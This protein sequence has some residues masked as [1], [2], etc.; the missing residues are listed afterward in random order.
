MNFC[1]GKGWGVIFAVLVS[2]LAGCVKEPQHAH[3]SPVII[4]GDMELAPRPISTGDLL[5]LRDIGGYYGALSVSPDGNH[6]AFQVQQAMTKDNAYRTAWFVV[7]VKSGKYVYAG[8]GGEPILYGEA[9]GF[10]NGARMAPEAK[11][12]PNGKW[13]AYQL[14]RDGEIQLW[15]SSA[16]G[17][18]QE[19]LSSNAGNV[20]VL[21]WSDSGEH[22]YFKAGASRAAQAAALHTE[23]V[24]GYLFDD[25]FK[26]YYSTSPVFA[27][28][29]M[30]GAP[31]FGESAVELWTI[32]IAHGEE[33]VATETEIETFDRLGTV[34]RPV[35]LAPERDVRRSSAAPNGKLYAWLENED[36]VTF[37]GPRPPLRLF[38]YSAGGT[39]VRCSVPESGGRLTQVFWNSAGDEV[40]FSRRA[41]HA[42]MQ[43][44]IYAWRP[45]TD[46]IRTVVRTGDL[47]DDCEMVA[48][49]LICIHESQATPRQIVAVDLSSGKFTTVFDPNPE[50]ESIQF[51]R[52]ETLNWTEAGGAEAGGHLVYPANYEEGQRYPLVIVQYRS[53]GFLRGGVGDEYP[54]HALAANGF[55]VLSFD[56]PDWHDGLERIADIW[57][58]DREEWRDFR[59][60]RSALSALEIMIDK[61]D[62]RE[63]IDPARVGLTGLSDGAETVWYALIH[64]NKF[65]VVAASSG[66]YSQNFYYLVNAKSRTNAFQRAADLPAP[67]TGDD[68]RWK[69]IVVDFHVDRINTPILVQV[70]DHE[71]LWSTSNFGSLADAGKPIEV[72][73]FPDEYH[74]KWQPKHREA[75]YDRN[76]DWMNFWLRDVED[77]DPAKTEQYTRW[78]NMREVRCT[79]QGDIHVPPYCDMIGN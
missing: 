41:G 72:Y 16:D 51:S 40:L 8:D 27:D 39:E 12:S 78:R 4:P 30:S 77:P 63:L 25:R 61:L 3:A 9:S 17:E 57:E 60:R 23:G 45:A 15:R 5:S 32:D 58:R 67:E 79:Q 73:V 54:I 29:E 38:A 19:K 24:G 53:Q 59:E 33:R 75:V 50:F 42:F 64:S 47:L 69:E 10:I 37:A 76:I 56:R 52:V 20:S 44:E 55:F 43:R 14:K 46:K 36:P 34:A 7:D 68:S 35:G 28:L 13:F 6:V 70:A 1:S 31:F 49:G 48:K 71:L 66:G 21:T 22:I 65:A 74:V 18:V 11:W 62:A 26:P 2:L